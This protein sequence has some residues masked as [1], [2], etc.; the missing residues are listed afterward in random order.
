VA[1]PAVAVQNLLEHLPLSF[2]VVAEPENQALKLKLG[3]ELGLEFELEFESDLDL[4]HKEHLC[5]AVVLK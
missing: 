2:V 1:K 4:H 5:L 3:L